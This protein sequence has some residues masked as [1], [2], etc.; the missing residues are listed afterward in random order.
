MLAK[1]RARPLTLQ[2]VVTMLL[3]HVRDR[4]WGR[5]SSASWH[6]RRGPPLKS[7]PL[8]PRWGSATA[9]AKEANG[10][11]GVVRGVKPVAQSL[12]RHRVIQLIGGHVVITAIRNSVFPPTARSMWPSHRC[13]NPRLRQRGLFVR[14]DGPIPRSAE[15]LSDWLACRAG[16][17]DRARNGGSGRDR[18]LSGC[19][20]VVNVDVS[21]DGEDLTPVSW[22]RVA[23]CVGS[24][25]R[26]GLP[27]DGCRGRRGVGR[28]LR[29]HGR[30]MRPV[31]RFGGGVVGWCR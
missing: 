14:G 18:R 8:D 31:G 22:D 11:G 12:S 15:T 30:L 19:C 27:W 24:C 26:V 25:R 5:R 23:R 13:S 16:D 4:G 1:Y 10:K 3:P 2:V 7:R 20:F 21:T 28:S 9:P 17:P 29:R 6:T